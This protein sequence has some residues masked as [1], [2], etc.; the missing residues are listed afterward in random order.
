MAKLNTFFIF[1][2]IVN[3]FLIAACGSNR[4][5]NRTDPQQEEIKSNVNCKPGSQIWK[6]KNLDVMTFRNGDNI[7]E[8]KNNIDWI[9][10]QDNHRPAWCFYNNDNT[11]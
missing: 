11:N 5:K 2:I 7:Q 1:F 10:A 8:A 4:N 6:T 9:N 3:F